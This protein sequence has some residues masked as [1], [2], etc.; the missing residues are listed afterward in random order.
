MR[1][2]EK[3]LSSCLKSAFILGK[4]ISKGL[5]LDFG[6]SECGGLLLEK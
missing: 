3:R 4:N 2:W 5:G 6:I 1:C